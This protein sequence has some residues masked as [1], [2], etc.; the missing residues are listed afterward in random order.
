[1]AEPEQIL[2]EVGPGLTLSTLA[3]QRPDKSSDQIVLTSLRHPHDSQS[4]VAVL[5][6]VLGRL[7]LAGASVNWP[8]IYAQE[9][10]QRLPLP[11]YPFERQPYW[12]EGDVSGAAAPSGSVRGKKPNIADWFFIPSWQQAPQLPSAAL[13]ETKRWL[14]FTDRSELA[15]ALIERLRALNQTVVT[16]TAG[17]IFEQGEGGAYTLHPQHAADYGMLVQQLKAAEQLPDSVA[18]LWSITPNGSPS[19]LEFFQQVQDLGYYSLMYLTQALAREAP[20][21]AVRLG[22][23]SNSLHEVSGDDPFCPEKAPLVGLCKVI[24]QE[25]GNLS[26]A[27]IDVVWPSIGAHRT[28]KL[29]DCLIG[30]LAIETHEPAVAYR[31]GRRW[32][33]HYVPAPLHEDDVIKRPL[34]E[35]GVYW[36]IGGLGNIGYL[37]GHYL[38]RT[39]KARLVLSSRSGLPPR[40][41]WPQILAGG[42]DHT[43]VAQAIRYVQALEDQGAEV[44]VAAADIADEAQMQRLVAEIDD[45]FGQ[46]NGVIHTAGVTS[47]S[48]VHQPLIELGRTE[49]D[50]QFRPK[51]N[52]LYILERTLADRDLD[53][54]L[55]FSSSSAILG[56]LGYA[57]YA[58]ANAFLDAFAISRNQISRV[59][60]LS[61]D[62]DPWPASTR[63]DQNAQ[64][65]YGQYIMTP[66]ESQA[67]FHRVV[68]SANE[69]Q[70]MVMTGDLPAR[71]DRWIKRTASNRQPVTLH[72]RPALARQYIA[73]RNEL[74]H[75]VAEVWSKV[76]GIEQIGVYD[77]FFELGGHS[78]LMPQI[79]IG[80]RQALKIEL[81]VRQLF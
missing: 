74:E 54:Y 18:H 75:K 29:V 51:V 63:P 60:W 70:V 68:C 6:T 36:I 35:R 56:G 46:L 26:C 37:I 48:S 8:E 27:C 71:L 44:L 16:V 67:A 62:W 33:Q 39:V 59:P 9:R 49:S 72:G 64:T 23:I 43:G 20:G 25:H 40:S 32:L 24:P 76:L 13:T 50:Q 79:L 28:L 45:R 58:A 38:A 31:G 77:N 53:F 66:E 78:L 14:V 47:G 11:T 4:D 69:G 34:R 21:Q 2:L 7:W 12:I 81:P 30:E 61:A 15:T 65:S 42:Q 80:L 52:G 19:N 55:L 10:R 57:A 73:P 1:L 22:V 3:T 41:E 5:L 17:E